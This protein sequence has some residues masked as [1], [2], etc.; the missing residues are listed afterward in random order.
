MFKYAGN[1]RQSIEADEA[2]VHADVLECFRMDRV[3]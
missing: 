2:C 1:A 3:A